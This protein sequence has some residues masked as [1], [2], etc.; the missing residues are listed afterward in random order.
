MTTL[1]KK[2][3]GRKAMPVQP[4]RIHPF[5]VAMKEA[6]EAKG[7]SYEMLAIKLKTRAKRDYLRKVEKGQFAVAMDIG[8]RI[9]EVLNIPTY[10]CIDYILFVHMDRVHH[11]INKE[12]RAWAE[13]MSL[14]AKQFVHS[15]EQSLAVHNKIVNGREMTWNDM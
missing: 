5:T 2:I 3:V 14:S 15:N 6:R 8:L 4:E 1:Y 9:C 13:N 10:F 12:Y 7:Y 11:S